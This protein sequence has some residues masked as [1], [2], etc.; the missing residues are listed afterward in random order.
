MKSKI[1]CFAG[2]REIYDTTVLREKLR[3]TVKD[4]IQTHEV[5]EFWV[6][7]YGIFDRMCANVIEDLRKNFP[8]IRLNLVVPYLTKEINDNKELYYKKYHNIIIA[9]M[10]ETTPKAL[11]II[12]CN[13]YMIKSSGYLICYVNYGFG[14]AAK[15]LEFARRQ[16][17]LVIINLKD[18]GFY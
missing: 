12:K 15:T 8:H 13:E 18:S 11:K 2:H 14:G 17:G 4:L 9:D 1:C 7:N 6:G 5:Y 10:P 3:T 16:K